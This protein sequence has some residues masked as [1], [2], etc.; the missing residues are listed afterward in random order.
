MDIQNECVGTI[1][2]FDPRMDEIIWWGKY[3]ADLGLAPRQHGNLSFLTNRNSFII[4]RS[5][6]ELCN[7]NHDDL[8]EVVRRK[9]FDNDYT[10]YF[11]GQHTPSKEAF[12]HDVIYNYEC[13]F[14]TRAIFHLHDETMVQGGDELGIAATATA[15]RSG[16]TESVKAVED[17]FL[18]PK[19]ENWKTP[20]FI[21]KDHG[22]MAMGRGVH[23]AGGRVL[24]YHEQALVAEKG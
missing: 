3:L 4:T 10:V 2:N 14:G 22:I 19:C 15:P 21:L 8:V 11:R 23:E 18:D 9:S 16:T 6:V 24:Y 7:I 1:V 5:G 13:S 12:V 17:F 20:Y